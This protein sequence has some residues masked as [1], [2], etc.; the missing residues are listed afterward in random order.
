VVLYFCTENRNFTQSGTC[1]GVSAVGTT[2]SLITALCQ[3]KKQHCEKIIFLT[4]PAKGLQSIHRKEQVMA[5]VLFYFQLATQD[6]LYR[7]G[8]AEGRKDGARRWGKQDTRFWS[9]AEAM[10][11]ND[12]YYSTYHL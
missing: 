4:A 9:E 2:L 10:G 1:A 6:D 12:G 7:K 11:Y 3:E 5:Q 8:E